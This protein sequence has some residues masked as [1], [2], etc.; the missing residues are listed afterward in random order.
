MTLKYAADSQINVKAKRLK[1]LTRHSYQLLPGDTIL[2][3]RQGKEEE[4]SRLGETI[5]GR[6]GVEGENQRQA[7]AK[8]LAGSR[9][10]EIAQAKATMDALQVTYL[11]NEATYERYDALAA[12][13]A[14]TIP[15]RDVAKAAF[16][17]VRQQFEA[18]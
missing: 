6:Q 5:V 2:R 9:P 15:Q 11:N 10:E 7:L 4:G 18:A 17:S 16:G 1:S 8:L 12:T 13:S 14:G 3:R